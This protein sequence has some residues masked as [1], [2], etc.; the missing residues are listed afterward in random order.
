MS[1]RS[2]TDVAYE[3]LQESEKGIPFRELWNRVKEALGFADDL[4]AKKIASFY[5]AL[6]LDN[7]FTA[8]DNV[9]DL[10]S[11]YKFAETHVDISAIEVD[12]DTKTDYD[13]DDYV[14]EESATTENYDT[15]NEEEDIY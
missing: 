4:A 15:E 8:K 10:S 9:W 12:D 3:V 13:N 11:R 2:M 5:E 14:D 7:R 6:S 1:R